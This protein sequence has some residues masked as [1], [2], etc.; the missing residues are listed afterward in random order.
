MQ[1]IFL[2][3]NIY[4]AFHLITGYSLY[5]HILCVL[6]IHFFYSEIMNVSY[7]IAK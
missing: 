4:Y 7:K 2:K 5:N 3:T 6:N 1:Y